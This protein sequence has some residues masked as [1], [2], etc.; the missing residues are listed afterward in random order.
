MNDSTIEPDANAGENMT[1]YDAVLYPNYVH[2]QTHPDRLASLG[3]LF[4]MQPK[5]VDRA[6]VLELACGQGANLIPLAVCYPECECL[7]IDLSSRQI[8]HGREIVEALELDNIELRAQ[9]ILDFPEDAGKF[10]YIIAH[11]VYSWVPAEVRDKIISLCKQHLAPHGIAIVSYNT[12]PGWHQRRMI[13]DM[14][15]FHTRSIEE[16]A[17]RVEQAKAFLSFM[18]KAIPQDSAYGKSLHEEFRSLAGADDSYLFHEQLEDINEPQYFHE[19]ADELSENELQYLSEVELGNLRFDRYPPQVADVLRNME[20]VQREQYLDFLMRR[21][22]RQ[23]LICHGD[24]SLDRNALEKNVRKLRFACPAITD[25][26]KLNLTHGSPVAF[27]GLAGVKITVGDA[28]TK[29]AFAQLGKA[30]PS[31]LSFT[32]LEQLARRDVAGD[33]VVVQDTSVYR[34]DSETV[35]SYLA[36][37]YIAGAIELHASQRCFVTALSKTPLACPLARYQAENGN[38]LTTRLHRMVTLDPLTCCLIRNLDGKTDEND[39]LDKLQR[40]VSASDLVMQ[41][42]GRPVDCERELR[43]LLSQ[44]LKP[45]LQMLARY[46]LLIS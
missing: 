19:F 41:H 7:G 4:G 40:F 2:P 30:W 1:S 32:E 23:T 6:R 3:T 29:A 42:E 31:T 38:R 18:T 10:D 28:L 43:D 44:K 14:M 36:Q 33:A 20:V 24:V 5:S 39:L 13:R 35:A 27:Q 17:K 22:F 8:G 21:T 15:G 26:Q 9:S 34:R 37:A 12:F 46:G 16:P 11:G 25:D 45:N